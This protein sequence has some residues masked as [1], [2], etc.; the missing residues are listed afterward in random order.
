[1]LLAGLI[2]CG[3]GG[4]SGGAPSAPFLPP[5]PPAKAGKYFTHVVVLIQENRTF[6]NL[7][8]TFPGADG[9]RY[10][11]LHNGKT[12]LLGK[13]D[14]TSPISPNNGY[15]FWIVDWDNGKMDGFDT[16]PIRKVPG[17]YVYRYVDPAQIAPYWTL[18]KQYVLA[19]HLFQTEGSG[20]F[21]AH[22]DLIRGGTA[23]SSSEHLMNFPSGVPW[24]C[25]APAGTR[26]SLIDANN[27][28]R[29]GQGPFPCLSYATLRDRLDAKQLSW[30]YYAP[31]VGGGFGGDFW[32]AFDAIGAVR[33]GPEWDTNVVSPETQVMRD[34]SRNTLPSVSW[35]IPDAQNSD[36]PGFHSDTGPSWVAQIVNAIGES[37]AWDST[38]IMIVWDD[39]G[40][41]YDHVAPPKPHRFGGLG[42]RVPLL[43]VSPYSRRG[44]VSHST[45]EFG[46]IVKFIEENW[47]LPPLGTTDVRAPDF[48]PDF[49][50]FSKPARGF[51]PIGAKYSRS[52]FLRQLPSNRPVDNE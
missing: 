30:R 8:A 13:A 31:Q 16:V 5:P 14:L 22:Q 3:G 15:D 40:G 1:M 7:F 10:G 33:N 46:S 24:G 11:K 35:V 9:T 48:A 29:A 44:Y 41:W 42:F 25:D 21:T 38:V 32:N 34:I 50:D 4:A 43:V 19:D 20:S 37:P 47:H 6:D 49:F 17:I 18:A 26:T 52:F 51:V 39:W 2:G 27:Q 23:I 28:Y 12:Y 36:H 45:Y